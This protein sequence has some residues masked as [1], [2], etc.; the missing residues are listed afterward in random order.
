LQKPIAERQH[1]FLGDLSEFAVPAVQAA[2]A[3]RLLPEQA[4]FLMLRSNLSR[5]CCPASKSNSREA[6]APPW[7]VDFRIRRVRFSRET[8]PSGLLALE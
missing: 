7:M 8:K 2:F 1:I 4:A 5:R 3:N 6:W